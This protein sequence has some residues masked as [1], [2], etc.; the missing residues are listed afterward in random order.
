[1]KI[2]VMGP[3]GV[4][5]YFGARLA[6]A[7]ND[8]TF[9]ARGAHLDAMRE[10]GLRLDSEIGALH[11]SPVQVVADAGEIAAADAILFAVKMRDTESAARS[12]AS[13]V[14]KGAAVFTFQNGV[15]SAERVGRIV[16]A[17]NVVPGV[18]RI[19]SHISEPGVIKQIGTFCRLE[20]AER[21][22]KPSPRTTAL[23]EACKRAGF[24]AVMPQNIE[25]EIWMKFAMLAPLAGMTALT[26]LPIGPIRANAQSRVLL[27]AAVEETVA[28]GVAL[29]AGLEPADAGAV[30]RLIDSFPK[31][32]MASMAHDLLAGKPIEI[33]GLSGAVARLG[34]RCGVPA[35]THTFI[36]QALAPFTNGKP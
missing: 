29:E 31:D 12:L 3:G 35:P 25:R 26:R 21:D 34:K 17:G 13:L 27:Q 5:G 28:V 7:G 23:L 30:M 33:D 24:E 2:A 4:G 15:E 18:A 14:A 16:G 8:V 36:A 1:M 19:G 32:L 20:F 10:S 6:A 11:L 9:V 22:G